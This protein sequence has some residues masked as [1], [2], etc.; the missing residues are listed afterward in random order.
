M[1]SS[2]KP[3][4]GAL[5]TSKGVAI[6]SPVVLRFLYDRFVLGVYFPYA[7]RCPTRTELIPFFKNNV[8][9]EALLSSTPH[10]TQRRLLDIGVG[11]GYFLEKA[12][13]NKVSDLVLVDLNPNCLDAASARA[14]KAHPYLTCSTIQADFLAPGGLPLD[15]VGGNKFDAISVMLLLHCLPGPSS[16]KVSALVNLK[17]LLKEDNGVL[18]GATILGQGF[19]HNLFGRFLMWWHNSRGIFDNREDDVASFVKP[20][21]NAFEDV[22]Y[23]VVGT[24]LLFEAR[25]PK[26]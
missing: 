3:E 13:L 17:H 14:R 4:V 5:D 23:R 19:P 11:T 9:P 26:V 21:Q 6:Y 2:I 15:S 10:A 22:R 20:L 24:V 16:C 18:F 12:P 7:W 1:N 8:S 25:G